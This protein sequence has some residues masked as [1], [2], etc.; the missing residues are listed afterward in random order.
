MSVGGEDRSIFQWR[1]IPASLDDAMK[2][3]ESGNDSDLDVEGFFDV[4]DDDDEQFMAIKPWVGVI[5]PPT[6]APIASSTP[7]AMR[8]E[9]E[10]VYGRRAQD[11]RNNLFYAADGQVRAVLS[12][13]FP[14]CV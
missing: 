8:L 1:V 12:I 11:V 7:P 14:V 13:L 6:V 9:L 5:V 4:D 10:H 3:D 2:A